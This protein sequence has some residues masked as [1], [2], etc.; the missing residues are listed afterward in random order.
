MRK[1][2]VCILLEENWLSV[3]NMVIERRSTG[4]NVVFALQF[5]LYIANSSFIERKQLC[6]QNCDKG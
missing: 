2:F 3:D 6:V 4:I 5:G 1:L